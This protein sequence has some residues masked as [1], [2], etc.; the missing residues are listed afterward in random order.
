RIEAFADIVNAA[1]YASPIRTPRGRDIAAACGQLKSD[2]VKERA[3]ARR[4]QVIV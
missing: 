2:S 3:S 1:G 4:Q